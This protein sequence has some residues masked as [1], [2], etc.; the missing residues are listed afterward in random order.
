MV[1]MLA[2]AD[3]TEFW[4]MGECLGLEEP[5][6][7]HALS[8]H[9]GRYVWCVESANERVV[10]RAFREGDKFSA[11]REQHAMTIARQAGL[12]V[13][14]L[15]RTV[16]YAGRSL[17]VVEWCR[18]Q[19]LSSILANRPWM[20]RTLGRI[21]GEQQA[22]LHEAWRACCAVHN[23][24]SCFGPVDPALGEALAVTARP[25]CLLHLDYHPANVVFDGNQ[26]SGIIDWTNARIGDPR[27]D[28]AR[29]WSLLHLVFRSRR[30]RPVRRWAEIEFMDAWKLGYEC[31]AGPQSDM[32]LFMTWAVEGL[33]RTDATEDDGRH[34]QSLLALAA[35]MRAKVGLPPRPRSP[36]TW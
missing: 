16:H 10:V 14:A 33:I 20:A 36:Y 26:V 25:H 21:F 15:H 22:R 8:A 19:S 32:P 17:M 3:A 7:W 28:L 11:A 34:R 30:R 31:L 27:A 35:S 12:P 13:P 4:R 2:G 6:R 18:G 29:T 24:I 23:W 9:R 1:D 5:T